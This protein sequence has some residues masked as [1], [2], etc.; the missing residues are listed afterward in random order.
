M[1]L[2]N[3]IRFYPQELILSANTFRRM[4]I[5]NKK[6]K[7]KINKNTISPLKP[8]GKK[9]VTHTWKLQVCL[10]MC[11]LLVTTKHWRVKED[12]ELSESDNSMLNLMNKW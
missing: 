5:W 12:L 2:C 6:L 9:K 7:K 3:I 10:S 4:Q 1:L 11:D 8:V